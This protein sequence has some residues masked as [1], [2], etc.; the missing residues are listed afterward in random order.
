MDKL[1]IYE[2]IALPEMF[3]S[4][5]QEDYQLFRKYLNY[6]DGFF[7]ELGAMDGI[8]YSNS[9]FFE[10]YLGWKGILIE[11]SHLFFQ[12]IENRPNTKN[13]KFVISQ[14]EGMV[15]FIGAHSVG[16]LSAM[17]GKVDTL[18]EVN[19]SEFVKYNDQS[20]T[21][22]ESTPI[23]KLLHGVSKVDL[24]SID[25]EGGEYEVLATFD[26]DIPVHVILLENGGKEEKREKCRNLLLEKGFRYD[27]MISI[28][29]VW[30]NPNFKIS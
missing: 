14:S 10:K 21:K 15:D 4:Q 19:Q 22:I 13:Y 18:N 26:W 3:Y 7:I 11:P 25:V 2:N 5:E 28:N 27:G 20:V 30:V 1:L 9:L 29:E 8:C 17:A 16:Y 6:R 23:S 24:F 12:L